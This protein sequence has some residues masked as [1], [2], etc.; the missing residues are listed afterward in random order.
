VFHRSAF[1]TVKLMDLAVE[2]ERSVRHQ[3]HLIVAS[4]AM[5]HGILRPEAA[6]EIR[7]AAP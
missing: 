6:V 2:A 4:Y 5:G 1:G 3:G 7:T